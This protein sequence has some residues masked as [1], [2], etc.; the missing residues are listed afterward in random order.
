MDG[1][2]L[3]ENLRPV[4]AVRGKELHRL[5]GVPKGPCGLKELEMFQKALS[6]EYQNVVLTV[7]EPDTNTYKGQEILLI[8]VDQHYDGCTSYGGFLNKSYFCFDYEKGFDHPCQGRKCTACYRKDCPDY[9]CHKSPE[10]SC[11][12]CHCDFFGTDCY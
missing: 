8:Q 11:D 5:A 12:K 6:P 2:H 7:D 10:L 9:A 4:Q 1:R 3:Y